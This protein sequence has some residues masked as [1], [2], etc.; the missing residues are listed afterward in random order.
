MPEISDTG[1]LGPVTD[2][3]SA[4]SA[5]QI[6]IEQGEGIRDSHYDD[7]TKRELAHYYKFERIAD[8]DVPLGDVWPVVKNP[9]SAEYSGPLKD[10]SHLFNGCYSY[11]PVAL[12]EIFAVTDSDRK[13][14]IVFRGLFSVM[15]S[16]MPQLAK[17]MMQQPISEGADVNAGPSFEYVQFESGVSKEAQL[18]QICRQALKTNS[19]LDRILSIITTLPGLEEV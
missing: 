18:D 14:E 7:P 3:E 9:K 16:V 10:L 6:I 1:E 2:L 17:M 11:M 15:A 19:G 12:E 8:G 5:I 13:H 4:I